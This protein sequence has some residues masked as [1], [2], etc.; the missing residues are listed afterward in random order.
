M[1]YMPDYGVGYFYSINSEDG[2]AFD[3]IGNAIRAYITSNLQKPPVPAVA[4]LLA[5]AAD[6]AGWYEPNSPRTEITHFISDCFPA[7]WVH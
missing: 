3:K 2:D 6:Y 1:A 5:N 4:P 7:V